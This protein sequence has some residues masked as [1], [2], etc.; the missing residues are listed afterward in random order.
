MKSIVYGSQSIGLGQSNVVIAGGFESMSNI[1]YYVMN[2]R[3]GK[4]F[5]N[6]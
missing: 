2:H 6:E 3:K 5:G 4:N 1:P